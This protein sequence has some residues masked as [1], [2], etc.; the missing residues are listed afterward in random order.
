MLWVLPLWDP[1]VIHVV[2]VTKLSAAFHAAPA[3]WHRM[4]VRDLPGIGN[5]V[6][7]GIMPETDLRARDRQRGRG[8]L[9]VGLL[10]S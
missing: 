3:V 4:S 6:A 10:G 7:V 1:D 9:T 8:R 5:A 2:T